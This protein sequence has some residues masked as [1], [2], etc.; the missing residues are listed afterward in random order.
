MRAADLRKSAEPEQQQRPYPD[1]LLIASRSG[2]LELIPGGDAGTQG[3]P[4]SGL[5]A[6]AGAA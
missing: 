6:R 1:W 4:G 2:D 5:A 3:S